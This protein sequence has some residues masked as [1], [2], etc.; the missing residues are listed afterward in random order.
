M[1]EVTYA[2]HDYLAISSGGGWGRS[3]TVREAVRCARANDWARLQTP[4]TGV[5]RLSDQTDKVQV[6]LYGEFT[7]DAGKVVKVAEYPHTV[8]VKDIPETLE[9]VEITA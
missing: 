8:K 1:S 7:Y 2:Q 4:R 9:A 5:W 6:G 3:K